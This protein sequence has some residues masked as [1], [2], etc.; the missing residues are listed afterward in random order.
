MTRVHIMKSHSRQGILR[1]P[2]IA[3][4]R[5]LPEMPNYHTGPQSEV[6]S[7]AGAADSITVLSSPEWYISSAMSQPP[8][9]S[10]LT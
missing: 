6:P 9:N 10:P 5:T 4:Q 7:G 3:G 1:S 2:F 8:I